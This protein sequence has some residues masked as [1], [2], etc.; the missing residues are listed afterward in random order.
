MEGDPF[1]D[2]RAQ[3]V[4]ALVHV[5]RRHRAGGRGLFQSSG[6]CRSLKGGS[7]AMRF[8]TS[9]AAVVAA[10]LALVLAA[11]ATGA[12]TTSP[13][14]SS[15]A[16]PGGG[17]P[18]AS[19]A[20]SPGGGSPVA[21]SAGAA[22]VGLLA[23]LQSAGKITSAT[24]VEKPYAYVDDNGNVTGAGPTVF[25]EV[26]KRLGIPQVDYVLTPF[27]SIIAGLN[28]KRWDMSGVEFFVKP[29]RC[30]A[31]AFTNPTEKH[32]D[33][34]I[35]LKGNPQ[36]VHSYADV[37]AKGLRYGTAAGTADIQF[38]KDAGIPDDKVIIFPD[39][40]TG[41]DGLRAGRIDVEAMA[42]LTAGTLLLNDKG[43]DVEIATPFIDKNPPGY[44]GFAL[45][46]EDTDLRAAYNAALADLK[47][48]GQLTQMLKPF[49][50]TDSMIPGAEPTA[51][52][53]CPDAPWQN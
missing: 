30:A 15:A 28:S 18:V 27:D 39:V 2:R 48:S 49:G 16:S 34:L 29:E 10:V 35:V 31:V 41:L 1:R 24:I 6:Q 38:A 14:A 3:K 32:G 23:R 13:V 20:A 51:E 17:S 36:G 53:L 47:A 46:H 11:C 21:S 37:I 4:R 40:V 45:R 9:R 7:S 5:V 12:A 50:F 44:S 22:G 42:A 8:G 33:A 19:S 52:S 25:N 26:M 43:T